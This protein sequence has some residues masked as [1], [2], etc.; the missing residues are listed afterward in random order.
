VIVAPTFQ[1]AA[2]PAGC[3]V[4]RRWGAHGDYRERIDCGHS[5]GAAWTVPVIQAPPSLSIVIPIN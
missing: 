2:V 3:R 1:G 4:E 5:H